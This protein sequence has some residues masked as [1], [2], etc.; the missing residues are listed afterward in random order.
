MITPNLPSTCA[1]DSKLG[2]M[3]MNLGFGTHIAAGTDDL[4]SLCCNLPVIP[5]LGQHCLWASREETHVVLGI[6]ALPC[7]RKACHW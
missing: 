1:R 7:K 3:Y 4:L 2:L 6:N 5:T